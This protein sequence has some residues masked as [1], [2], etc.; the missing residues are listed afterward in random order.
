VE[1][2]AAA[3]GSTGGGGGGDV[4]LVFDGI[5]MGVR[6]QNTV[7][8]PSFLYER[9]CGLAAGLPCVRTNDAKCAAVSK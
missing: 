6:V 7:A 4:L 2:G 3:Q 9:M 1:S 5:K 8:L